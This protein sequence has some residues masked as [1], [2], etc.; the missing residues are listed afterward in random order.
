MATVT[1]GLAAWHSGCVMR[2]CSSL[3]HGC[4]PGLSDCS[5]DVSESNGYPEDEAVL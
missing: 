5:L 2:K 4:R 1:V 3:G